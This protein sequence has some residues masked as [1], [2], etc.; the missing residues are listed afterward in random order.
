MSH[1]RNKIALITGGSRGLG[2]GIA[3][4]LASLLKVTKLLLPI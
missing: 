3:R 1:L 2:A 4:K